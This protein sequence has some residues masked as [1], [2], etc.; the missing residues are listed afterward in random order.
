MSSDIIRFVIHIIRFVIHVIHYL[1][2]HPMSSIILAFCHPNV[3]C[4]V[5]H[6][7][8]YHP[9]S[10]VLSSMSSDVS[11]L[12]SKCHPIRHILFGTY[13]PTVLGIFKGYG[14]SQSDLCL[15]FKFCASAP[16]F[17]AHFEAHLRHNP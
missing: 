1:L 9:M 7:L 11:L 4:F 15:T 16:H 10:S 8:L 2:C 17:E 6:Y 3:I 12:S 14:E 13:I 5:I